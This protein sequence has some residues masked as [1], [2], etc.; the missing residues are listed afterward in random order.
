[1][2]IS[3]CISRTALMRLNSMVGQ[4]LFRTP[5]VA[6]LLLIAMSARD[7]FA[8]A[9]T[10]AAAGSLSQF[11][12]DRLDRVEAH[13]GAL[14]R[15]V[16]HLPDYFRAVGSSVEAAS[17]TASASRI[18]TGILLCLLVG[19]LVEWTLR[20]ATRD[21]RARRHERP[22]ASAADRL[23]VVA[24]DIGV[25]LGAA[26]AF[27]V[28]AFAVLLMVGR[29]GPFNEAGSSYLVALVWLRLV[30]AA[31]KVLLRPRAGPERAF[32]AIDL[33]VPAARFW[34]LALGTFVGWLAFGWAIVVTLRVFGMPPDGRHLMAYA[35]GTG[36]VVIGLII[37]W[38]PVRSRPT[39]GSGGKWLASLAAVIL[40]LVWA[41]NA[42]PAFWFLT[43]A[44]G[45]PITIGAARRASRH[46]LRPVGPE[47]EDETIPSVTAVV[48]EQGLRAVLVAGAI[49]LLLWGW[50]LDFGALAAQENAYARLV[51]GALHALIIVLAADLAWGLIKALADNALAR[52]QANPEVDADEARRRARIRTLLPIGRNLAFIVLLVMTLLM[53]LSSLGVEIGPLIA[54][55]GVVG[56]AVGFGAQTV[57]RD[58]ISGMF[59]MLDDAFRVGEYIQSGSYKGTVESF[60]LRS[61]KLRHQ[62]GPLFTIPFGSLGAVQNMSRDWVIVKDIIGITYDSDIDKAKKLIKQIG[63]ELAKDPDLSPNILQPLK[64]QGVEQFDDYG[65]RIRTKMMTKPG[66]QFVIRRRA[67]AMIKR[68]FDENGIKFA[69]PKVQVAHDVDDSASA[70]AQVISRPAGEESR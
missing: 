20:R 7:A 65:L 15:A 2:L 35:L 47:G 63:L 14:V 18:A 54:S 64:M 23:A 42:M 38:H 30:L 3:V 49:W 8:Q 66:E 25:E 43:V 33:D 50:N 60:S 68:A 45:L 29:P 62:R 39:A 46:L 17:G 37:I 69:I 48:V 4:S 32:A 9:A 41:V 6:V 34:Y 58:I 26:L 16:P 55:A 51:R 36:L 67:N 40:W 56:V 27:A 24:T 53:V 5:L 57:V 59:Y 70:A 13:L 28:G 52:A 44:I 21:L 61:I 31:L 10:D 22:V 12:A 11:I 19:G 1:M